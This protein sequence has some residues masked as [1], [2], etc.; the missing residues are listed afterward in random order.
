MPEIVLLPWAKMT[1]MNAR[2]NSIFIQLTVTLNIHEV[3]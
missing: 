3:L 1:L 2:Q